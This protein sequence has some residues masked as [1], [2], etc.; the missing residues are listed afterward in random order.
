[1]TRIVFPLVFINIHPEKK[2]AGDP[3]IPQSLE[4]L[5]GSFPRELNSI[6]LCAI[7]F[8]KEN[9]RNKDI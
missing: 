1:M 4:F 9:G 6:F 5:K 8:F 3:P 2:H 7:S